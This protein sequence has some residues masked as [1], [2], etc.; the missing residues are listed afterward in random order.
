MRFALLGDVHANLPAL[1]AVVAHAQEQDVA[2]Y[3]NIGDFVGYGPF[4]NEV[5]DLL[6]GINAQSIIGNYDQ[7]V[8]KFPQK[9]KKW[10]KKKHPLKYSAFRW[11]FET[12]TKDYREYLASLP[13][14]LELTVASRS[15]L[16]T[17]ASPQSN[18]EHLTP[19][20][21]QEHLHELARGVSADL[22]VFGHS[23]RS[24]VQLI[25]GVW[26][27]N[28]GSVGRPDDGD[29]RSCYAI[30]E[31][32]DRDI[33][34]Q[35]YRLVYDVDRTVDAIRAAHLPEPFAQMMIQGYNLDEML[36]RMALKEF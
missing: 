32:N 12:L 16:L 5:I 9:A 31:I 8:L 27:V 1:Q 2:G 19:E 36:E 22:V 6:R 15:I 20:T 23:H 10:H 26:F 28:T 4:P 24:F 30:L 33:L 29:P 11:A 14:S 34:V 25:D 7:K 3:W 35:H 21:P 13:T 18:E 17:H